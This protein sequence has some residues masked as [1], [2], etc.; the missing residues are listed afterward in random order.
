MKFKIFILIYLA[1]I[2]TSTAS[3]PELEFTAAALKKEVAL[4]DRIIGSLKTSDC[5]ELSTIHLRKITIRRNDKA[6]IYRIQFTLSYYQVGDWSSKNTDD[7]S[8]EKWTTKP[9]HVDSSRSSIYGNLL[10]LG[11]KISDLG[12]HKSEN[13]FLK[14]LHGATDPSEFLAAWNYIDVKVPLDK[15]NDMLELV[16]EYFCDSPQNEIISLY[17]HAD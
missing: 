2:S 17:G 1:A 16:L 10:N 6:K 3:W 12:Y 5:V 7:E 11:A 9:A 8:R 14:K 13:S 15:P 4:K